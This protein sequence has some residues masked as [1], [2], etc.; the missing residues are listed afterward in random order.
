VEWSCG[1]RCQFS[2]RHRCTPEQQ[3]YSPD[4]RAHPQA[5]PS[6]LGVNTLALGPGPGLDL[7]PPAEFDRYLAAARGA[8][9]DCV[10][11]TV[12]QI[13]DD[14]D[15]TRRALAAHHL[16]CSDVL[17]LR[18]GKD[19][20]ETIDAAKRLGRTAADIGA[21]FGL[22]LL[23]ARANEEI[24]DRL[25][26]CAE[27]LA[28]SGV[29]L[30]L[31]MPPIGPINSVSAAL[32]VVEAV[33]ADRLALVIEPFHFFRGEST[34][35]ELEQLPLSSLGYLQFT[36]A[37]VPSDDV[38]YDATKRRAMPGSGVF[39]LSRFAKTFADRGWSGLVSVEV[40]SVELRA[41]EPED[42]ARLAYET[43]AS[44]WGLTSRG[45]RL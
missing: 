7:R 32:S 14:V 43:S 33:G 12:E 8:G 30:V 29:R 26:R 6:S 16:R 10:S 36:D 31:E 19:E 17:G 15:Q 11:L 24:I 5:A 28:R 13:G 35:E 18:V 37:L 27:I 22:C 40:L 44:F 9:F 39:D 42:F 4:E 45:A 2:R 25:G 1:S 38:V 41:L 34:W 20:S 23:W 3:S 21:E